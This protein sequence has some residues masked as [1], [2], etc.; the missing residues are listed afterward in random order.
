MNFLRWREFH[1][2]AARHV[3]LQV[4]RRAL[5]SRVIPTAGELA[6]RMPRLDL[7]RAVPF[8][9]KFSKPT[10]SFEQSG[11]FACALGFWL[12]FGVAKSENEF[13]EAPP[14]HTTRLIHEVENF[15]NRNFALK[16]KLWHV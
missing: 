15:E 7:G 3:L 14:E 8:T 9:S 2:L 5:V 12:R 11:I 13:A 6:G 1:C 4:T 16:L 10:N